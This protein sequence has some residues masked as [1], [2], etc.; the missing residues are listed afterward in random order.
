MKTAQA[1]KFCFDCHAVIPPPKK[2]YTKLVMSW[3]IPVMAKCSQSLS[4]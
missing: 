4:N 1:I 2:K 3:L